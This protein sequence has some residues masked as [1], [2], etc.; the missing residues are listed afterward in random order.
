VFR[1]FDVID[2]LGDFAFF[3]DRPKLRAWRA[4]LAARPSA[5]RAVAPDYA[6]R[7]RAFLAAR[8]TALGLRACRVPT[9]P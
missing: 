7:L 6:Q 1:Y 3:A 4:A 5:Q 8:P 9:A 2:G